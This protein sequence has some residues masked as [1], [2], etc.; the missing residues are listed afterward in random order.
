MNDT[1]C[2]YAA[3]FVD[4]EGCI[5]IATS[6]PR[7]PNGVDRYRYYHLIVTVGQKDPTILNWLQSLWGGK[8][9][10]SYGKSSATLWK[11]WSEEAKAFLHDIR[12]YL[13]GKTEQAD[14]ALALNGSITEEDKL[15]LQQMKHR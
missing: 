15:A 5:T 4:G 3:G 7:K 13:K 14:Y 12:P 10:P 2:A 8:M 6:S 9:Y 11:V 1:D